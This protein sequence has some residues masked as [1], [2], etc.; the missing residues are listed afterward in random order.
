VGVV[1][2]INKFD[3]DPAMAMAGVINHLI[4]ELAPW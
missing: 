1:V 2:A 3:F 4:G